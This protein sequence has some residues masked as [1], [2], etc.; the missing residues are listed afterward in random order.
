[1]STL[2]EPFAVMTDTVPQL[3]TVR[4]GR[5]RPRPIYWAHFRTRS[6]E[7][8]PRRSG[9]NRSV[10]W[11]CRVARRFRKNRAHHRRPP[12]NFYAWHGNHRVFLIIL[13]GRNETISRCVI[14]STNRN[15]SLNSQLIPARSEFAWRGV[16]SPRTA[17]CT[18]ASPSSVRTRFIVTVGSV[19]CS[20]TSSAA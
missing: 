19:S 7:V 12:D 14:Y 9:D 18:M 16:T 2:S 1:M 8:L 15:G 6:A 13:D 5:V 20:S 17:R 4:H 10:W 11:N 3:G